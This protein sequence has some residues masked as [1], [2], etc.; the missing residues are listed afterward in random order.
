VVAGRSRRRPGRARDRST[1]AIPQAQSNRARG[2]FGDFL[3][4]LGSIG[5]PGGPNL[6]GIAQVAS[7]PVRFGAEVA[8]NA[9]GAVG[10]IA[11]PYLGNDPTKTN[12]H[13]GDVPGLIGD[14]ISA[15][16][17]AVERQAAKDRLQ[18]GGNVGLDILNTAGRALFGSNT[19]SLR[20]LA[21]SYTSKGEAVPQNVAKALAE[22]DSQSA[23]P[24][25][26]QARLDAG[27]SVDALS[28][29]M[30][31]RGIGFNND[32]GANLL[33]STVLDPLNLLSFGAGKVAT[34]AK[35]AD[36]AIQAGEKIGVGERF[37]GTA[38]NAASR[39]LSAGGAA[40]MDHVLGP[41]ASGVFHALGTAPYNA[42][43]NA[44]AKLAPEYGNAFIDAFSR[45]AAQMPRAVIARYMAEEATS[46]IQRYGKAALSKL[47]TDIGGSIES[48]LSALRTINNDQIERRTEEL[49]SRVAPDFAGHTD[50]ARFIESRDKL[51]QITGMSSEDAARAL[52]DKANLKT[53]Q[54]IHLAFYGKAGDDLARAKAAE[55]RHRQEHR[56]GAPDAHQ[57]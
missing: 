33:A 40:L 49:L 5:I 37:M 18:G 56:P 46:D 52:G 15:P 43:K 24:A 44:A 51:A 36:R 27:E 1:S 38:Y 28:Q 53:A 42:V 12:A 45:G 8:G 14:V 3:G 9:L 55:P 50:D 32:Q 30:A 34:A 16:E 13:L 41:S 20:Q 47:P 2:N 48:R 7:T 22:L 19:D 17:Q 4:G 11:L 35:N 25:D 31:E 29:V 54:T 26:I 57:R 6:G 10:G 21:A 39:G 23:L